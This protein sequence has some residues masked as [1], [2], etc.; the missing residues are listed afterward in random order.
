MLDTATTELQ[1]AVTVEEDM[2][3]LP[4]VLTVKIV[5]ERL[6]CTVNTVYGYI[7][8]G[9]LPACTDFKPILIRPEDY[10]QFRKEVWPQLTKGRRGRPE[11]HRGRVHI[12]PSMLHL[13]FTLRK[14]T[15]RR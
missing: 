10:K 5:A 4:S 2:P 1:P 6:G 13:I 3:R 11:R 9:L 7:R 14:L 15:G 12:T 8:D